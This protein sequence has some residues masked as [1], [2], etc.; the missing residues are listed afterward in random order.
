M[1][2]ENI[3]AFLKN[4]REDNKSGAYKSLAKA[5]KVA[6]TNRLEVIQQETNI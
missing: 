1:K 5:V 4:V 2:N 6:R 3:K